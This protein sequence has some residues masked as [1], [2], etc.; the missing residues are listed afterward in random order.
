[1]TWLNKSG[2][3][4]KLSHLAYYK[5]FPLDIS[6]PNMRLYISFTAGLFVFQLF[7]LLSLLPSI[8]SL[9]PGVVGTNA[10]LLSSNPS[11]AHHGFDLIQL[12][13]HSLSRNYY[14]VQYSFAMIIFMNNA[15]IAIIDL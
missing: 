3:F 14:F 5:N 11:Y 13:N 10:L 12:E 15:I 2:G 6:Y 4:R 8:I 7:N 1:M 9:L